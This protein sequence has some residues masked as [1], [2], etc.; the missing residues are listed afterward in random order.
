MKKTFFLFIALFLTMTVMK[1]Q[2]TVKLR[3]VETSDVHGMFFPVDY[4]TGKSVFGSMAR[5]SSYVKRKRVEYGDNLILLDNGDIL[6]GQPTNYFWNFVNTNEENIAASIMNYMKYDAQV[7]GNHDVETGHACYDKWVKELNCPVLAANVQNAET[8]EPYTKAYT[9]LE[10]DG[11][12]IAVLGMLTPAV[13]NWL[14]SELWS[15]IKFEEVVESSKK[16]INIIMEQEKPDVVVGLFHS[17]REGGIVTDEYEENAVFAVASQ[18]PGFDVILFGHD[19]SSYMGN[20]PCRTGGSSLVINPGNNARKIGEA[21]IVVTLN[22]EGKMTSK[23]VT[24]RLVSMDPESVDQD[25]MARF[26]GSIDKLQTFTSQ[27]IG[28]F[29]NAI[30]TRDCFFGSAAFSDLIHNL[31]LKITSADV[32]F[33]APLHFDAAINEGDVTMADMFNLYKYE[34]KLCVLRMTGA[35]IHKYLE[36]SYA[37]WTN[38]MTSPEDHI[39]LL[40]DTESNNER[41]GF[42]N[43]YFNFDSA[44]GIDYE[45]DV[46]K[47]EGSKIK[48]LKMSNGKPFDENE[49]YNV[50]MNSYRANGGGELITRGAGIPKDSID[51]RIAYRSELDQRYYLI[52]EIERLGHVNAKPNNNWRFVPEAWT[53]PAIERDYKLIFHKSN[54]QEYRAK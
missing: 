33:N 10:R 12:R 35:E 4:T 26:K 23:K 54:S 44:A 32:S 17:G 22:D 40:G 36:M 38:M 49:W 28:V 42:A 13:P 53:K 24:G 51:S 29:D 47:P 30:Y 52:K 19:H 34:N 50:A 11:V 15:G 45:V 39:M 7:F 21:E 41:N 18:V 46:T 31:Q 2:R 6:Q 3:V 1:A 48:I 9:V 5:V 43:P 16:W 37:I 8:G 25:Y 27:K 14:N 20:V